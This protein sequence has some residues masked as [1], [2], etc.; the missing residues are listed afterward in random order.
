MPN[1]PAGISSAKA[2]EVRFVAL[3][4]ISLKTILGTHCAQTYP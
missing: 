2:F 1:M 3:I 4:V